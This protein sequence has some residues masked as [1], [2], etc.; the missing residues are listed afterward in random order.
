MRVA[1]NQRRFEE[2][3]AG[4][5]L[6]VD[7]LTSVI[8]EAMG[9]LALKTSEIRELKLLLAE[10]DAKIRYLSKIAY[11][12]KL[13]GLANR[14]AFDEQFPKL[15]AESHQTS[16]PLALLIADADGLKRA[17]ETE[18]G[19]EAGD[20]LLVAV[21]GA[22]KEK[23]RDNDSVCRLGGDEFCA[24]MPGFA[25]PDKGW[26]QDAYLEY[27]MSAYQRAFA[28]S[29]DS[30]GL[31]EG[32]KAGV[33]FGLGILEEHESPDGFFKRVWNDCMGIKSDMYE[34]LKHQGIVFRDRRK[35]PLE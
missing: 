14:R 33:T 31:P 17:N 10:K 11:V 7:I 25:P 34:T 19:Y 20:R 6:E 28:E 2:Q 12:D 23:A 13:T 5:S 27:T 26:S 15:V 24:V 3:M 16:V 21:A 8:G 4:T 22:F 29:V 9:E 35:T 1:N 18:E 30:S 32:I